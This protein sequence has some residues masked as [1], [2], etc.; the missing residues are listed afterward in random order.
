MKNWAPR[1][2]HIIEN[3][4]QVQIFVE[5]LDFAAFVQDAKSVYAVLTAFAIIG[6]AAKFVP[7]EIASRY[8]DIPWNKMIRM[9][10]V[11]VHEYH[12]VNLGIVWESVQDDLPPLLPRLRAI[13]KQQ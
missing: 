12:R 11:L 10:N 9:R 2:Q 1:V 7:P 5:G 13:L 8:P 4:E 3:I 6:E